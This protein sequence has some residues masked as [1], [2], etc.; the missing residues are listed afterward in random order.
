MKLQNS[1]ENSCFDGVGDGS[2]KIFQSHNTNEDINLMYIINS[3]SEK[4]FG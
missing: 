1:G 4:R 2:S 3:I